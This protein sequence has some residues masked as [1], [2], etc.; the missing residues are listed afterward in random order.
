MPFACFRALRRLPFTCLLNLTILVTALVTG[1]LTRRITP[2]LLA[3]WGF[4]AGD[5]S[6]ERGF[7]LAIAAFQIFDPYM[8]VSMLATVL[9]LVGAC[10]YRLGTTRTVAVFAVAHLAGL[11]A[12]IALAR[13][14]AERGSPWGM[15]LVSQQQVGASAGSIGTLGAWIMGF[16]RRTRLAG[17]LLCMGFL[18]GA[19]AGQ[20]HPWDVAHVAS[21]MVGLGMGS[22][23]RG[24]GVAATPRDRRLAVAWIA[25][26]VGLAAVLAPFA[27]AEVLPLADAPAPDGRGGDGVRWLFLLIGIALWTSA[28]PLRRGERPA[29]WMALA[30]GVAGSVAFWQPGEPGVEHVLSILLAGS[31]V[32]WRADFRERPAASPPNASRAAPLALAGGAA[33]AI[34]GFVALRWQFAP[35]LGMEGSVAAGLARLRGQPVRAPNW[36]SDGARWFLDA[37]P[38]VVYACAAAALVL[39]V[40]S[41]ISRKPPSGDGSAGRSVESV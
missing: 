20:V 7:R 41:G 40:R 39:I 31:L 34:L 30:A 37:L 18:A 3:T 14:L 15:L 10:E 19:F 11:L 26:I 27:V 9:A 38:V 28:G 16:P 35:P 23:W 36:D 8:A 2:E 22:T 24:G 4:G 13:A 5:L 6:I 32:W 25:V 1:T 29:W 33:F 17:I 12:V 21:F